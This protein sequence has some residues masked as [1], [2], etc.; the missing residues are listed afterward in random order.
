M[1]L[2]EKKYQHFSNRIYNGKS[3]EVIDQLPDECVNL[4]VTSPPY[5]IDL[6]NKR[7]KSQ[8]HKKYD[9][10]EDN[11]T[12]EEFLNDRRLFFSK[13][14]RILTDDARIVVNIS[15]DQNGRVPLGPD[16]VHLMVRELG[17]KMYTTIVWNKMWQTSNRCSWGSFMSPSSP[18]FPTPFEWIYVFA[19]D[20]LKLQHTGKSDLDRKEF[21][22]WSLAYWNFPGERKMPEFDHPAM[23]PE[24]LPKRC[25]KMF[26]Y[27]GDTVL[28]PYN[29]V[30]TTCVVAKKLER[31]YI[32]ID[33]SEK[34]CKTAED[35][36]KKIISREEIG[37]FFS[38]N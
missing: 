21:I 37:M 8:R 1:E 17:Y 9:K 32:G 2:V 16:F 34:Y 22:D 35:R 28:D 13:V 5:N 18:S 19:K 23:F 31:K 10:Y 38:T 12:H 4:I 7:T 14:K 36:L 33:L 3:E 20:H 26:S 6:G 29:G 24:E 25:I 11:K 15:D 27:Q 30:G